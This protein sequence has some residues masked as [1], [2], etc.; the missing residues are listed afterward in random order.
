MLYKKRFNLMRNEE[1]TL[2][3]TENN[4]YFRDLSYEVTYLSSLQNGVEAKINAEEWLLKFSLEENTLLL[5]S[6]S[7]S[8][9]LSNSSVEEITKLN[10]K[11]IIFLNQP[12]TEKFVI[13]N[14]FV[15]N[16]SINIRTSFQKITTACLL[17]F[18]KSDYVFTEPHKFR[19]LIQYNSKI[20]AINFL[21]YFA[22]FIEDESQRLCIST[23][24]DKITNCLNGIAF[25]HRGVTFLVYNYKQNINDDKTYFVLEA[26]NSVDYDNYIVASN[27]IIN[28]IGFF[29]TTYPFGPYMIFDYEYSSCIAY[30]NCLGKP[31]TAKYSMIT[32]N[33]YEYYLDRDIKDIIFGKDDN[34]TKNLSVETKLKPVEKKQFEKMLSLLDNKN[35]SNMFFS[36]Q[37]ISTITS[38]E[39]CQSHMVSLIIYAACLEEIAK[40]F[41]NYIPNKSSEKSILLSR[42]TRK[43]LIEEFSMILDSCKDEN[44]EDIK[45]I[46]NKIKGGLFCKPNADNLSEPFKYFNVELSVEDEKLLSLRNKILH[47]T[48]ILESK[49]DCNNVLSYVTEIN[50]YCLGFYSLIWRLIMKIIDYE[51]V[52]R[53][54]AT[55]NE[56]FWKNQSNNGEPFI[57]KI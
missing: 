10:N 13:K 14:S 34:H 56:K 16:Q 24:N 27:E 54:V 6:N 57:K 31:R 48:D 32:L 15:T 30:K 38:N 37:Q 5:S 36:L 12:K 41:N 20:N 43:K 17:E 55:L 53:D 19:T 29:T 23:R 2:S 40:W 4:V 44:Q 25:F 22:H 49:L 35:F 42:K 21:Y 9:D 26:V 47:G 46:K 28:V 11:D 51:G 7:T 50:R 3:K 8:I 1:K 39:S 52:Y 33:P 45:K 18:V